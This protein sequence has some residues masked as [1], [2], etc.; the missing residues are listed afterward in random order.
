VGRRFDP[1]R[2]HFLQIGVYNLF[3]TF[4]KRVLSDYENK[5]S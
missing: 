2:A 3:L 4:I 1:D 5:N